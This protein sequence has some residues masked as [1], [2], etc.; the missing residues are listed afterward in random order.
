MC[1]FFSFLGRCVFRHRSLKP[2]KAEEFFGVWKYLGVMVPSAAS[3][4][5]GVLNMLVYA[6]SLADG[7]C[8]P[9]RPQD[10]LGEIVEESLVT[11]PSHL[12]L[13]MKDLS[14]DDSRVRGSRA[15]HYHTGVVV[16]LGKGVGGGGGGEA[17][18][19]PFVGV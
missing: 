5:L 19:H 9:R 2:Q 6:V 3:D 12:D 1:V 4:R 14:P 13:W 8:C 18:L 11:T 7:H 15:Y 10:F 17:C 16:L